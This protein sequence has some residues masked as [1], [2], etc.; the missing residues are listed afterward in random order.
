MHEEVQSNRKASQLRH[1]AGPV[2]L[3]LVLGLFAMYAF[4]QK[5]LGWVDVVAASVFALLAL[6]NLFRFF[7]RADGG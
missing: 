4:A 2:A 5:G 6:W 3:A 1:R 7:V